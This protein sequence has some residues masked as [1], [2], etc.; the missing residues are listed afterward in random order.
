MGITLQ[1]AVYM[2]EHA[3]PFGGDVGTYL[4]VAQ[5]DF[6]RS[7]YDNSKSDLIEELKSAVDVVRSHA[8]TQTSPVLSIVKYCPS[9]SLVSIFG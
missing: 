2:Q 8:E 3:D 4:K 1:I 5:A 7:R 6:R 9:S